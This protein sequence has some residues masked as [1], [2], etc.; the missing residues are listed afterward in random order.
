MTYRCVIFIFVA[1]IEQSDGQTDKVL[2]LLFQSYPT[3]YI[4]VRRE[5]R[6]GDFNLPDLIL[7]F[8]SFSK[9]VSDCNSI[10]TISELLVYH[11]LHILNLN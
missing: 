2:Q 6:A 5:W 1:T 3:E 4:N 7:S 11:D 8:F 10:D 9:S